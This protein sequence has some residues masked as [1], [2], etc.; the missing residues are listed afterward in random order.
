MSILIQVSTVS[1]FLLMKTM[2]KR[3]KKVFLFS[4]LRQK[5]DFLV[6]RVTLDAGRVETCSS[7]EAEVKVNLLMS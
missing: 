2:F 5:V 4:P 1:H 3:E 7:E 6:R